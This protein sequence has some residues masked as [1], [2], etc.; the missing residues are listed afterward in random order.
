MIEETPLPVVRSRIDK[1]ATDPSSV[2]SDGTNDTGLYANT[3][4][5]NDNINQFNNAPIYANTNGEENK[6]IPTEGHYEDLKAQRKTQNL[7]EMYD[8]D[9]EDKS[10]Y[11]K[12]QR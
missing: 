8:G 7:Y 3:G 10:L 5:Q 11:T 9:K 2:I 6:S 4:F 1:I 12:L